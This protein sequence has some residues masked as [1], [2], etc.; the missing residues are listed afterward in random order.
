MSYA[1]AC[2]FALFVYAVVVS[3]G[4]VSGHMS[5]VPFS[6]FDIPRAI[7]AV[8]LGAA[9]A[10]RVPSAAVLATAYVSWFAVWGL[11]AVIGPLY[12]FLGPFGEQRILPDQVRLGVALSSELALVAAGIALLRHDAHRRR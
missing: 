2:A 5:P 9:V 11:A 8:A 1:A 6:Q 4:A 3:I 12:Q 10:L 7:C